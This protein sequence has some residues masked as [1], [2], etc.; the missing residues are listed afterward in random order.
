MN[1]LSSLDPIAGDQFPL[2]MNNTFINLPGPWPHP[3]CGFPYPSLDWQNAWF[4]WFCFVLILFCLNAWFVLLWMLDLSCHLVFTSSWCEW[5]WDA[6]YLSSLMCV[7]NARSQF[8]EKSHLAKKLIWY[9]KA[10][11]ED[12]ASSFLSA[13][14]VTTSVDSMWLQITTE[15]HQ[16]VN[17]CVPTK[18]STII[19]DINN[20]G[21]IAPY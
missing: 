4:V 1:L 9:I 11:L 10:Q 20:H 15:F 14:S 16:I 19:P 18:M 6:W 5:P 8:P 13:N 2:V 21:L 7:P 3:D 12:F 17:D